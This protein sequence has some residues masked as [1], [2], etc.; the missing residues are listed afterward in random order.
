MEANLPKQ[1]TEQSDSRL[2]SN[3]TGQ[4]RWREPFSRRKENHTISA[5]AVLDEHYSEIHQELK[6]GD[7]SK[8]TLITSELQQAES[9]LKQS[10][11]V[12]RFNAHRT[13]QMIIICFFAAVFIF[14]NN[15]VN[16]QSMATTQ[17]LAV[18]IVALMVSFALVERKK[19][20]IAGRLLLWSL[21][22]TLTLL[23]VN[24]DGLRD[25]VCIGYA[26][27]LIFAAMLGHK[28]QF[29][30][31]SVVIGLSFVFVAI[32]NHKGW[33]DYSKNPFGWGVAV[34]F[35]LI[36]TVV[37]YAVWML[38]KD[39]RFALSSLEVENI[40]V[41]KSK[42][43]YQRIAHYDHLTGLPNRAIAVERFKQAI[44]RARRDQC[45]IAILFLDLDNFKTV[46]D[47]LGHEIGDKLLQH[48]A[49]RLL[50]AVR[51]GDT[52]CRL[53]GDEFLVILDG[54]RET[55]DITK[56]SNTLLKNLSRTIRI[57]EHEL[58]ATCSIG[59]AISPTDGDN[60]DDL[61]KK[62][63][64]A[65]YRAKNAGRNGLVFFDDAMNKDMLAHIDRVNSL[66]AAIANREFVLYYQPKVCL[67]SGRIFSAE[68]L[69]RWRT[70]SGELI[71]PDEFIP[72][73]E[74]TGLI[75]EIGE[76]VLYEACRQCK[77][78]QGRGMSDF[79]VAVNLSSIQFRRG[80]LEKI[81]LAAL[82]SA[83]L[84][85][86]YLELEVTESLLIE[87]SDD[88][89]EQ[90]ESLQNI[91][92]TFSIDDFGTGY[93]SLS[94]LRDFNFDFLKIDRT[95]IENSTE[96][97][98]D[99]SLCEAIVGMAH[100]LKLMVVAE[101]LETEEQK[102]ALTEAGCEFG[103]GNYFSEAVPVREFYQHYEIESRRLKRAT[104]LDEFV[105]SFV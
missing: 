7:I 67:K 35:L 77:E 75:I 78:F 73:A 61:R 1:P 53:G 33:I 54:I 26:G 56:I 83:K 27:I 47:S 72:I 16:Q 100:K 4:N 30:I 50:E 51:E 41:N 65:M 46:N 19:L 18:A 68:A 23:M 12:K 8:S 52:V 21:Y 76:W 36:F 3:F 71:S 17:V 37:S 6:I 43:A 29:A 82:E 105:G 31:L 74:N 63:D 11:L 92:V 69:I 99:M 10:S 42:L 2:E 38:A 88:I 62:A 103:Q 22:T 49:K 24:N 13:R 64:M 98:N 66:R 44:S 70:N 89:R 96:R 32:A 57:E 40:R 5:E 102:M 59:I 81:V 79:S 9:K 97:E 95:F 15:L 55:T 80:N 20:R 90:I 85:P 28:R 45:K 48:I 91:G 25:P 39:L 60:F 101:G 86:S 93:S 104:E 58:M 84:D 87:D 94:Y 34:D 14:I